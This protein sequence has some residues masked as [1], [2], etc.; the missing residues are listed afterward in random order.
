MSSIKLSDIKFGVLNPMG[1]SGIDDSFDRRRSTL[2]NYLQKVFSDAYQIDTLKKIDVYS[3]II[4][5]LYKKKRVATP[6]PSSKLKEYQ[7]LSFRTR[8]LNLAQSEDIIVYKVYIPEIEPR[9]AP[10]SSKDPILETYQDV[11]PDNNLFPDRLFGQTQ[12]QIGQVVGVRFTDFE[13]LSDPRIVSAGDVL[14]IE[15]FEN[16]NGS[17]GSQ[18]SHSSGRPRRQATGPTRSSN[19]PHGGS[20]GGAVPTGSRVPCCVDKGAGVGDAMDV[21]TPGQNAEVLRAWLRTTGG[22]IFEKE[23]PE[24]TLDSQG[25]RRC[26]WGPQLDNG[27]DITP[28]LVNLIQKSLQDIID[29]VAGVSKIRISGGNDAYHQCKTRQSRHKVGDA[30]DF[31]LVFARGANKSQAIDDTNTIMEEYSV[32]TGGLVRFKNEYMADQQGRTT[33]GSHFHVQM[34]GTNDRGNYA[35]A[36]RREQA[37]EITGRALT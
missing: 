35:R 20:G 18:G 14:D 33:T 19:T 4:V 2:V 30:F 28:R 37:G 23:I 6:D 34:G 15:D 9:P 22:K 11:L 12:F 13:N 10:K 25:N 24:G 27:G 16:A 21:Y 26:D 5:G 17:G 3:G 32:G 1:D 7:K 8:L 29:E 31:V 36:V